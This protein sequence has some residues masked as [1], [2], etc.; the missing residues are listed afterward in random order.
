MPTTSVR[1]PDGFIPVSNTRRPRNQTTLSQQN[2]DNWQDGD[3]AFLKSHYEFSKEVNHGLINTNYLPQK[4]TNHPVI[5]LEHSEDSKYYLVTTISAYHSGPENNYLPPWR[6]QRHRNKDRYDFRAFKGSVTPDH[7]REFLRLEG[8]CLLPKP[9]TSWVYTRGAFVVPSSTLKEFDKFDKSQGA[10]RMT[11]KSLNDLLEHIKENC[12][13]EAL[14][15]DPR[16]A[17]LRRSETSNLSI[18]SKPGV[19][20]TSTPST[21]NPTRISSNPSPKT[22]PKLSP[23]VPLWSVIAS[24]STTFHISWQTQANYT[25]NKIHDNFNTT[26]ENKPRYKKILSL[27]TW[28]EV[29][30]NN[31]ET[32]SLIREEL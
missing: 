5:I 21:I 27:K 28:R 20:T 18:N 8:G 24:K 6:Q 30:P 9:K 16:I 12:N 14:W 1:D 7:R 2:S 17:K 15:T 10:P 29:E 25:H 4:A 32:T 3:I 13:T 26:Q 22:G 23:G 31:M 19:R 11:K